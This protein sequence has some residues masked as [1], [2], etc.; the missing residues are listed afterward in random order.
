MDDR[1]YIRLHD[2][3]PDHPKVVGLTDAAFRLYVEALCWCS[4]RH[5]NGAIAAAA[6]PSIGIHKRPLALAA[7]LVDAG[8]WERTE[9]GGY[10]VLAAHDLFL[11][12][13][14]RPAIPEWLR[15]RV[16]ER[17]GWRCLQCGASEDLSL[18]H[19]Y[20]WSLGGPDIEDN[21]Q[22]LCRPCNSRKGA[23]V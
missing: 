9:G 21:L 4:R 20:P 7:E 11:W 2:G 18:D 23:R 14:G 5:A 16:Y 8:L 13:P 22:T 12:A 10:G 17:N 3:M 19:I 6:L 15:L 1:T